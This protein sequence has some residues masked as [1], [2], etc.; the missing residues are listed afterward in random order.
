MLYIVIPNVAFFCTTFKNLYISFLK[1]MAQIRPQQTLQWV[2]VGGRGTK[3]QTYRILKLVVESFGLYFILLTEGSILTQITL[4]SSRQTKQHKNLA[5]Y[6]LQALLKSHHIFHL[7]VYCGN[8]SKTSFPIDCFK[9]YFLLGPLLWNLE[10]TSLTILE[11]PNSWDTVGPLTYYLHYCLKLTN[12]CT[13]EC[14][15][16][17]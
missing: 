10:V 4:N 17:Y 16:K 13:F 1:P 7:R 8:G 6:N 12:Y 11:A 15:N 2:C 14:H 9:I 5:C 3:L